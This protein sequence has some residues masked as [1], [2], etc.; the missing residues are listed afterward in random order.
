MGLSDLKQMR[1][2]RFEDFCE[3]ELMCQVYQ[4][5]SINNWFFQKIYLRIMLKLFEIGYK[6]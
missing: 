5:N 4:N 6:A 2:L 3:K 1:E